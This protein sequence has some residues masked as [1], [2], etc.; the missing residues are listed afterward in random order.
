MHVRVQG[1]RFAVDQLFLVS[2]VGYIFI[3]DDAA[4]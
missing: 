1:T 2:E 4:E 3:L